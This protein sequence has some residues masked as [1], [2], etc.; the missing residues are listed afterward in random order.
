MNKK[1]NS[2]KKY[3][4][5]NSDKK[6]YR[7]GFFVAA[8]V[9]LTFLTFFPLDVE[10][11]ILSSSDPPSGTS[12]ERGQRLNVCPDLLRDLTTVHTTDIK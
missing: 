12:S 2:I 1:W 3:Q 8:S 7:I 6:L 5:V 4:Y 11:K 9:G 10:L